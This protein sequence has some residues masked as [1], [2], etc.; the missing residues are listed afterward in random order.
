M[1]ETQ[2]IIDF[3][4]YAE[5]LK[6]ELRKAFKSDESRESV[7]EHTWRVSLMLLL[8]VPKLKIEVDF[9][10]ILKMAIIH[11]LAEIEAKD[12][13]VLESI[14]NHER[15][16]IKEEQELAAMNN[17]RAMPGADG[18]EIYDLWSE[19]EEQKTNEARALKAIDR[20]EGQFQFLSENVTTFT[21]QDQEAI[22][23]LLEETTKLSKIDPFIT[24]LDELTM[25]DRQNRIKF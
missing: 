25:E 15:L 17:I 18:Q 20:L 1:D 24:R 5:K 16:S 4:H 3:I 7:A 14:N 23:K 8:I 6:T 13:P 19:Y 21:E 2:R 10:K 11:D 22:K 9:L 12:V